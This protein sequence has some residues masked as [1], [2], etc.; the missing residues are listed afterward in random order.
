MMAE[1]AW[2]H[3]ISTGQG[4]VCVWDTVDFTGGI[5]SPWIEVPPGL[6]HVSIMAYRTA[7]MSGG[8]VE[9]ECE[10]PDGSVFELWG[11]STTAGP[12][13]GLTFG[14]GR[15]NQW[16]PSGRNSRSRLVP[17][18]TG[19]IRIN[20]EDAITQGGASPFVIAIQRA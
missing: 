16:A 1:Q 20:G 13:F 15:T 17:L 19:R 18:P 10:V 11:E 7:T 3:E 9:V 6:Y 14:D 12:A 5:E 8:V 4:K 2:D